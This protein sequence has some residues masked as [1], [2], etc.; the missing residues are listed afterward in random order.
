MKQSRSPWSWPHS[1]RFRPC[2]QPAA[3]ST[4][5]PT[6]NTE[7]MPA[8]NWFFVQTGHSFK[9]DGK[10]LTISG[11]GP[12]TLMFSDRPERVTGDALTYDIGPLGGTLADNGQQVSVFID[13]WYDPA[14][15]G[16]IRGAGAAVR[17]HTRAAAAGAVRTATCTA[18]RDG[19]TEQDE[20]IR[21]HATRFARRSKRCT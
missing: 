20:G 18:V 12:Q 3:T 2:A 14:W 4:T 16:R 13:W 8:A 17:I 7:S 21:V 11:V 19:A 9:S 10:T 1:C 5:T 6:G 15:Y